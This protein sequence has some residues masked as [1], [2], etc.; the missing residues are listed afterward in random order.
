VPRATLERT[1][2][3]MANQVVALYGPE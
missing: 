2:R 1:L 3:I